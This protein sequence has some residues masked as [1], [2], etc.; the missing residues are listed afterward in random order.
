[1]NLCVNRCQDP[2]VLHPRHL[3]SR[4]T[5]IHT[6]KRPHRCIVYLSADRATPSAAHNLL[7]EYDLLHLPPKILQDLLQYLLE[8]LLQDLLQ[9]ILQDLVG[10]G[11]LSWCGWQ[12]KCDCRRSKGP[13]VGGGRSEGHK[14]T[15]AGQGSEGLGAGE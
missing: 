10:R 14:D 15:V 4:G 9:D 2:S 8:D 11:R 3:T 6:P 13:D 12:Q 5:Y 7:H 1:M